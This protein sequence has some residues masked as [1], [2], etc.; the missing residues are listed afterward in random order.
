MDYYDQQGGGNIP[1]EQYYR[2]AQVRK[3]N[4]MEIAAL[5]MAVLSVLTIVTGIGPVFFGSMALIFAIL[6]KGRDKKFKGTALPSIIV[7]VISVVA[8]IVF[9]ITALY[10]IQNDPNMRT[11]LDKNFE[12]M[13]GVDYEGFVDGLRQYYET[14]EMPDF[15]KDIQQGNDPYGYTGGGQL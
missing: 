11:A 3:T 9:T 6:S 13:Y 4:G 1:P 12:S 7:S 5:F 15:M 8:G 10:T 14:G 2:Y